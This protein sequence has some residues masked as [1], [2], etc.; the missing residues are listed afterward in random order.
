VLNVLG[1]IHPIFRTVANKSSEEASGFF[2]KSCLVWQGVS[3]LQNHQFST[4]GAW[5]SKES[6]SWDDTADCYLY[7]MQSDSK[8]VTGGRNTKECRVSPV[9]LT[10]A[11][12]DPDFGSLQLMDVDNIG[13]VSEVH[14]TSLFRFLVPEMDRLC[15]LLVRVP[16]YRSRAPGSIPGT[17]RFCEKWWVF[18]PPLWSTGQGSWLQVK[19]SEFDSRSY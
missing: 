7:R 3:R 2:S 1:H 6:S 5:Q 15:R 8:T 14:S 12:G 11:D 10:G 9:H 18:R 19:R 4:P 17:T 13:S 16:G